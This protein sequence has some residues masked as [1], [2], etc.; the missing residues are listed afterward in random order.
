MLFQDLNITSYKWWQDISKNYKYIISS[1]KRRNVLS[2]TEICYTIFIMWTYSLT[3]IKKQQND[4][5][6][7]TKCE[8]AI[9]KYE[10]LWGM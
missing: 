9:S 4:Y 6:P 1:K 3:E 8:S 10:S 2:F 5:F 7:V